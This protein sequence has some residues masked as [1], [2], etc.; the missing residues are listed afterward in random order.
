MKDKVIDCSYHGVELVYSMEAQM[1]QME[2]F[3]P[4][5]PGIVQI[6]SSLMDVGAHKEIAQGVFYLMPIYYER[7]LYLR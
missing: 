3:G 4:G 7:K 6:E 1:I 5:N 2:L